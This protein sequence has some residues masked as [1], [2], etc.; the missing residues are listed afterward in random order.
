MYMVATARPW[1]RADLERL[2]DDGNRY[3]VLD[4][5]LLVTPQPAF[6]HQQVAMRLAVLLLPHCEHHGI[7]SVVGPGAIPVGDSELQPDVAVYPGPPP[8][9][10]SWSSL[11][12]PILVVEVLSP[13]T[14]RRDLGIKRAAYRR[15][16]IPEYW[17]VD[18]E[19]RQVTVVR[20]GQKDEQV[21]DVLRWQPQPELP[22]LE[23]RLS[24]V[25]R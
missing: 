24:D 4:G 13:S 18:V 8:R 25:L 20:A 15:W 21:T 9:N 12:R 10:A 7:G 11:P 6:L 14:R 22:A 1:T 23:I 2:P 17:V 5:V 19:Q 16:K 3:E